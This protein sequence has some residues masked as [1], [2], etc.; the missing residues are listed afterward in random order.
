MEVEHG[1]VERS[2]TALEAQALLTMVMAGK[3]A[4]E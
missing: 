1:R 3:M 4:I 2:A